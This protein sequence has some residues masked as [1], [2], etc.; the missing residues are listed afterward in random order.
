MTK[1]KILISALC[2]LGL[3]LVGCAAQQTEPSTS[4]EEQG[5]QGAE[6]SGAA[7]SAGAEGEAGTDGAPAD[8]QSLERVIHFAFDSSALDEE[9]RGIIKA[10]AAYLAA[11]P[12]ARVTLE[13]HTDE[14]GTREYN[15]A[16]G[17]RR[18]QSVE[19]ALRAGGI[20]SNRIST[21]SF[22]EE[23][24]VAPGQGEQAWGQNRRVEFVYR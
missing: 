17:E 2:L 3:G 6:P 14:R 24:P 19:R 8:A 4:G 7:P 21:V 9:S 11:N 5:V 23:K 12:Q 16:L 13:G 18:A 20:A 1:S 15:L 10:N 22:G